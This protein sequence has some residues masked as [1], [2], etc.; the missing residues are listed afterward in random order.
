[1]RLLRNGRGPAR[2]ARPCPVAGG[3]ISRYTPSV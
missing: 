2:P 3:G 1:V